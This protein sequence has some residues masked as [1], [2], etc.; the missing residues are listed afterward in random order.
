MDSIQKVTS[1]AGRTALAALEWFFLLPRT[2]KTLSRRGVINAWDYVD[3]RL[4]LGLNKRESAID[5]IE[6]FGFGLVKDPGDVYTYMLARLGELPEFSFTPITSDSP[7]PKD[8]GI[9]FMSR[10]L[11]SGARFYYSPFARET[12]QAS[13]WLYQTAS[14]MGY[15]FCFPHE[16]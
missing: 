7:P 6:S 2:R 11:P 5:W 8:T 3:V 9:G 4:G 16:R 14:A 12:I 13:V 1:R 15:D 10:T